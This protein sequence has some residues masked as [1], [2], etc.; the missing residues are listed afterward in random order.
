MNLSIGILHI[1]NMEDLLKAL[2]M[3]RIGIFQEA[4]FGGRLFLFGS[5]NAV[6][7]LFL[8]QLG[9]WRKNRVKKLRICTSRKLTRLLLNAVSA[10]KPPKKFLKPWIAG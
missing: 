1:L 7:D 4:D 5:A 8:S 2:K 3:R 10:E 9:N 6:K